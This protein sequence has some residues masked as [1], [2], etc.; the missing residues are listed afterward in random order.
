[1]FAIFVSSKDDIGDIDELMKG[2]AYDV[3]LPGVIQAKSALPSA[4]AMAAI[5]LRIERASDRRFK[6]CRNADDIRLCLASG[7]MAA[8][9]HI[10]GAEPIDRDFNSLERSV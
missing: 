9:M 1:M 6:V 3:P 7:V 5:L 4:I 10:E 2:D 8:V